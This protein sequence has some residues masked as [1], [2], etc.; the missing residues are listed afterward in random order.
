MSAAFAAI[1]FLAFAVETV[2]GFGATVVTVTLA[3]FLM[4]IEA[5]LAVF[6]PVNVVLSTY[7]V[8]RHRRGVDA[9]LL[10]RRV[11]P[12]MALGVAAGMILVRLRG[13][14]WL[15]PAFAAFVVILAVLELARMRRPQDDARPLPSA[16]AGTAL[17]GAGVIHG[18]FA[19]GGPLVVWVVGR[20]VADKYRF[21][22]TLSALWLTLNVFLVGAWIADGAITRASLVGSAIL[23]APLGLGILVGERVHAWLPERRF[24][25]AVFLLLL[26]AG[27]ALLVR[28][29]RA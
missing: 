25:A 8:L 24:R 1:V 18:L 9:R 5:I 16:L 7:V 6:V 22:S 10:A 19:C 11:V 26:V 4:P 20:E 23:L 13:A 29:L 15:Q 27:L 21:R 17:A 14:G 3:A 28:T 12:Y 2:A